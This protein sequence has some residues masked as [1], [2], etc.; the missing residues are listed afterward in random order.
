[1]GMSIG[2][3]GTANGDNITITLDT[4]NDLTLTST[5]QG[6]IADALVGVVLAESTTGMILSG[7]KADYFSVVGGKEA[8]VD[9]ANSGMGFTTPKYTGNF[10]QC[11]AHYL[12]SEANGDA[13]DDVGTIGNITQ[14]GT[15]SAQTGKITGARGAFSAANRFNA[16]ATY[17]FTEATPFTFA[18][19]VK[20]VTAPSGSNIIGGQFSATN[21]KF[22][23][24]LACSSD[25]I[26][27][28]GG[29]TG[30]GSSWA[31]K[32]LTF[33]NNTWYHVI[34]TYDGA[35][36]LTVYVNNGAGTAGT[37]TNGASG[38][39]GDRISIGANQDAAEPATNFYVE[40]FR[41]YNKVLSADA[42]AAIYN[43]GTGTTADDLTTY[44]T[45]QSAALT[46]LNGDFTK[47]RVHKFNTTTTTGQTW[48]FDVAYDGTNYTLTNQ[49]TEAWIDLN[50]VQTFSGAKIRLKNNKGTDVTGVGSSLSGW[51]VMVV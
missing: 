5:T 3:T 46:A 16:S 33:D 6:Q 24:Y 49:A 26:Y 8:T 1:M 21:N 41:V 47:M 31:K 29:R 32:A 2:S 19:W 7:A 38:G 48:T 25:G 35:N 36:G 18:C 44:S 34:G 10:D 39:A 43:G 11:L 42:R 20:C 51:C 37:Y 13:L 45:L 17:G 22:V 15:V 12:L 40:D 4:A 14:V 28:V 50:G 30:T 9:A 23:A 27:A